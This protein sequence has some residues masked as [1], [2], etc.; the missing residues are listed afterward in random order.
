MARP[1]VFGGG[2]KRILRAE[3]EDRRA[4]DLKGYADKSVDLIH[5][6]S[7]IEHVGAWPDMS[8]MASEMQRVGLSGWVQTPA[9]EFPI[10]PHFRLPFLHWFAPPIRRAVLKLSKDYGSSDIGVR[11]YHT[12]R[13]NLFSYGEVRSLFPQGEIHVERFIFS[14]SYSARWGPGVNC[15]A[16]SPYPSQR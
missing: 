6:N 16:L 7:V 12:D 3:R 11:R 10:E 4:R 14:K 8:A 5:S 15:R 2:T 13:I 9:W 1:R